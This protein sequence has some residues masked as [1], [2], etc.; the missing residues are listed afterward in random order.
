LKF[1]YCFLTVL[2]FELRVDLLNRCPTM[3][4]ILLVPNFLTLKWG[5]ISEH[6]YILDIHNNKAAKTRLRR[7]N[8]WSPFNYLK[9]ITSHLHIWRA[10]G[11]SCTEIKEAIQPPCFLMYSVTQIDLFLQRGSQPYSNE[12]QWSLDEKESQLWN[13]PSDICGVLHQVP[14]PPQ[15]QFP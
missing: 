12:I 14:L 8:G 2:E 9:I 13:D 15:L 10:H 3:W 4:V 11:P 5:G 7:D 1:Y 6:P